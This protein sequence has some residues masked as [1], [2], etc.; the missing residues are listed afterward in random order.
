MFEHFP[1][2]RN[3]LCLVDEP[4]KYK[5][6][7]THKLQLHGDIKSQFASYSRLQYFHNTKVSIDSPTA[8]LL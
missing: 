8:M 5:S 4:V 3:K 2:N 1:Q 7:D 6:E